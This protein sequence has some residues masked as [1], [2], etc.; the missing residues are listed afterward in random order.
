MQHKRQPI[1]TNPNPMSTQKQTQLSELFARFVAE[2]PI[3]AADVETFR[4]V[5]HAA[6]QNFA[7]L[8]K[9]DPL[10]EQHV[11]PI[12]LTLL[13]HA[14][15]AANRQR[16]AWIHW[17]PAIQGELRA[18]YEASGWTD[19]CDWP[20]IAQAIVE[21]VRRCIE[22]DGEYADACRVF[23]RSS[24]SKGFQ[25]GTISPIL[26]ALRPDKFLLINNRIRAV[27]NYFGETNFSSSLAE[28]AAAN[29]AL[30]ALLAQME[31]NISEPLTG[32][33]SLADRFDLFAEWLLVDQK[34]VLR[35]PR[36]WCLQIGADAWAWQAWQ[37]GKYV[38]IGWDELGDLGDVRKAEFTARRDSLVAQH[39]QTT[40]RAKRS[41][42][43][44]RGT[45]QAWNFARQI[46]EGD[47][48]AV[49]RGTDLLLGMATVVGPYYYVA[50]TSHAHRQPVEWIDLVPR[51]AT[52]EKNSGS[53]VL[54]RIDAAEFAA[55][56]A[57]PAASDEQV[58]ASLTAEPSNGTPPAYLRFC[59]PLLD[60]LNHESDLVAAGD[61]YAKTVARAKVSKAERAQLAPTGS[62]PVRGQVNRARQLLAHAK[63][64]ESPQRGTWRATAAGK[65]ADLSTDTL[66][67]LHNELEYERRVAQTLTAE[68]P[69]IRRLAEASPTYTATTP[70]NSDRPPQANTTQIEVP[71]DQ[72]A[73]QTYIDETVLSTWL[74]TLR[75][76]KQMIFYGP[77]GTGKTH[78]AQALAHHL[79]QNGDGF[80]E[81]VQFHPAYAYEDFIQ[82]I[83]P[84][85][86][87]DAIQYRLEPGHFLAFCNRA[88]EHNGSC[89]LI[90]DEINRA[91]LASV[92]GELM[93]LLEYRDEAIA[94][95]AG[96]ELFCI[97][98]NVY[99]IGTMNTADRSIALVDHALRRRFAFIGLAPNYEL[100][101]RFHEQ[102]QTG[103]ATDELIALLRQVNERIADKQYSL[104]HTYFLRRN[105]HAEIADIW[106]MEIEPYLEEFFFDQPERVEEF[107]WAFV[108]DKMTR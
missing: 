21:L 69:R 108:A 4:H 13:P 74:R 68:S 91:N 33:L 75:R 28:Y 63:F 11:D 5:R 52:L 64:I 107:R 78:L 97:P 96:G 8:A 79:A 36:Y 12:L 102:N 6:T 7:Q 35:S 50:E 103:F 73:A 72:L 39:G 2:V 48:I 87:G 18:W 42:W 37:E 19:P 85:T 70:P 29:D 46:H 80:T 105:L 99:L 60:T 76:K 41:G 90:I 104:G 66:L 51:V 26:N 27:L 16:G 100:L 43:T 101:R 89:V 9:T 17:S 95:A 3:T 47:Q 84:Q 98:Q 106:Q 10:T 15:T 53:N 49:C 20:N 40:R 54:A 88:K 62:N 59:T 38:A 57:S 77:P 30:H 58:Q 71:L 61:L 92:F 93:Y 22:H 67:D 83:R 14:N 56:A 44:K 24:F 55:L 82:G 25:S 31:T 1:S 23:S 32:P 94:L 65:K 86:D 81:L 34:F 45:D